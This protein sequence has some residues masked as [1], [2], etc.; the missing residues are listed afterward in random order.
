MLGDFLN[1]SN[2][3]ILIKHRSNGSNGLNEF[4]QIS[5]IRSICVLFIPKLPIF[6]S[7][8][9]EQLVDHRLSPHYH[10]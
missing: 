9:L 5:L 2:N 3:L 4:V 1:K 7:Q 6:C 10:L 8:I